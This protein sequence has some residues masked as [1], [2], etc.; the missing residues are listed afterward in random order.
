MA[1]SPHPESTVLQTALAAWV[2]AHPEAGLREIEQEVDRQLREL[3]TTLV[4]TTA[5]LCET[6]P[7]PRCAA[8]GERMHRDGR[9]TITQTTAQ[10]GEVVL[11][12][13]R[14]RCPA[15]GAGLFPPR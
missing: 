14:W 5:Q 8:C 13:Q 4:A 12:G 6:G 11:A 15:C 7:P 2:S 10:D 9:Q 1:G 3:R